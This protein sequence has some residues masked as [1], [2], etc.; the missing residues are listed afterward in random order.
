MSFVLCVML[1]FFAVFGAVPAAHA[2][3]AGNS[4]AQSSWQSGKEPEAMIALFGTYSQ[5]P[6][7]PPDAYLSC[8]RILRLAILSNDYRVR[9]QREADEALARRHAALLSDLELPQA[10]EVMHELGAT[11]LVQ[12]SVT[13]Y[14]VRRAR[15]NR[16]LLRSDV[17]SLIQVATVSG[18][19][20]VWGEDDDEPIRYPFT[21]TCTDQDEEIRLRHAED[22]APLTTTQLGQAVLQAALLQVIRDFRQ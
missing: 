9:G 12:L 19:I 16:R 1:A 20:L 3:E 14:S 21:R 6:T 17:P 7:L 4:A 2:V 8:N 15:Q 18:E 13:E 22:G 11:A 10:T 5:V